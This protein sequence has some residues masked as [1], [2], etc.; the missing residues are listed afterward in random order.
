MLANAPAA[1]AVQRFGAQGT[2]A[3]SN[4]ANVD[5]IATTA[6]GNTSWAFVLA[7]A[8]DYFVIP[9]L[10]V[11]GQIEYGHSHATSSGSDSAGTTSADLNTFAIGPRVGYNIGI[12]DMLSFWP[13]L[14]LLFADVFGDVSANTFDLVIFAPLMVHPAPH[15]F[16]GLGP[17][18]QTDLASSAA[19]KSTEWGLEFTIGGWLVPGG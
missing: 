3:V 13:K 17:F 6:G 4:D 7:P 14:E 15:F 9:N 12:N 8:A 5:F 18:L 2:L 1:P 19:T 16:A 10:S 11:G